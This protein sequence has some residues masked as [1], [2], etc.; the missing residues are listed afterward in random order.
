MFEEDGTPEECATDFE[1]EMEKPARCYECGKMFPISRL[2]PADS[3]PLCPDCKY[4]DWCDICGLDC[5]C[6]DDESIDD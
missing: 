3:D 2:D 1:F 4:I 5:F 6:H